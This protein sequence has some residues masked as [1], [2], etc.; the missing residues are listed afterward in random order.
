VVATAAYDVIAEGW[1]LIL[2][3]APVMR[4]ISARAF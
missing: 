1:D 4:A 2:L 3:G